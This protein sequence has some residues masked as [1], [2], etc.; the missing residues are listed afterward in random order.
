MINKVFIQTYGCQMNEYDS[1][2]I[3]DLLSHEFDAEPSSTAETADILIMN[4]CSIREKAQEKVFSLLGQWKKLKL[5]NPNIRIAVGGCVASQEGDV[6][7]KRAPYVDI[8]FGPQTL[9]K[10]PDHIRENKFNSKQ[11]IDIQ[12]YKN[13]KFNHLPAPIDV[14]PTAFLSIMEGCNKFCSFCVVPYTRGE[15]LSRPVQDILDEAL[16]LT[17]KGVREINLLGQNVNAYQS[18]LS[19]GKDVDFSFLLRL[20]SRIDEIDRIRFTTSHPI[21][22]NLELINAMIEVPKLGNY[23]H[24]PVQSGSNKILKDMKRGYTREYYLRIIDRLRKGN[25]NISIS[26]DFIVGFPDETKA[27]FQQTLDLI[28]EVGFDQSFSFVYSPRPGTPASV[29]GDSISFEEKNERLR[30]LQEKISLNAKKISQSMIGTKQKVLI[31]NASKRSSLEVTGRTLNNK[32]VNF[33]GPQSLIG[34]IVEV[35]VTSALSNSLR[36]RL[37]DHSTEVMAIA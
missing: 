7:M 34:N 19:S 17:S 18:E 32:W 28:D 22:F 20:M 9:H 26:S 30:I 2:K 27:D 35:E 31:E 4:T 29:L 8:V 33:S 15:E 16:S 13:D 5:K 1:S 36:G 3:M 11:I 12:F 24:L 14:K 25:P 23:L 21:D 6:I 37:V 10:L